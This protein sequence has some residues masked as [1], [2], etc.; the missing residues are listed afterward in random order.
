MPRVSFILVLPC[1]HVFV[2][3]VCS[4]CHFN[5]PILSFSLTNRGVEPSHSKGQSRMPYEFACWVSRSPSG[6]MWLFPFCT[7][8]CIYSRQQINVSKHLEMA[9]RAPADLCL[10]VIAGRY[11]E[12]YFHR[13]CVLRLF[14]AAKYTF[15]ALWT[16]QLL[17]ACLHCG[18]CIVLVI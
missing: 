13:L 8:T 4:L 6:T 11:T 10:S 2:C 7:R 18:D 17:L 5:L 15:R 1:V 12:E 14:L 3:Q 16:I 9:P